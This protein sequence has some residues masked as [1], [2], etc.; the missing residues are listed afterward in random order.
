[1]GWNYLFIIKLQWCSRW[2]LWMD[3]RF[4][5]SL[6]WTCD[7]FAMLGLKLLYMYTSKSFSCCSCLVVVAGCSVIAMVVECRYPYHWSSSKVANDTQRQITTDRNL[8]YHDA[9][10]L[11]GH[12]LSLSQVN[13]PPLMMTSSMETFSALLALCE[14][15]SPVTGEFPAQRPVTRSFE[16]FFDLRLE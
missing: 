10:C 8:V 1:M 15:N 12:W 3:M 11:Y 5:P 4:H 2:S 6:F 16:V 9:V 7:Y 14:G 13:R